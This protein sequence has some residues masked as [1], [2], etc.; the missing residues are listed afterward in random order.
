MTL[1]ESQKDSVIAAISG[2]ANPPSQTILQWIS[3]EGLSAQI[4]MREVHVQLHETR[5]GQM[6]TV[7]MPNNMNRII[8]TFTG[9]TG[10][11]GPS[12]PTI[13]YCD[14]LITALQDAEVLLEAKKTEL[15]G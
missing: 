12:G 5:H 10:A 1:S 9:L 4:T 8:E 2:S 7:M 14:V 13:A 11:T 15:G 6:I 3:D